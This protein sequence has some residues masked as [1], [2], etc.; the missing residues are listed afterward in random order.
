MQQTDDNE[1]ITTEE[2]LRALMGFP[3]ELVQRKAIT[4][5]DEACRDFIRQS[6]FALLSSSDASG[7]CDVSPRGDGPGFVHVVDEQHLVI[8][9]RPGNKRMD[10]LR[11]ILS[12]PQIGM[13]FLIP[14]L[15]ETLRVNGRAYLTK[16]RQLLSLMAVR[17]QVPLVGIVVQVDECFLH[18][19]KAFRRSRLWE[20]ES[21]L[22]PQE[23]PSAAQ[24]LSKHVKMDGMNAEQ[25]QAR[26]EDSY[27]NRLY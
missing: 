13:L 17:Q 27:R 9:E 10:T 3:S 6:P 7:Q 15:G 2:E 5:L 14:G 8:P 1:R 23:L 11:N 21:W 24:M 26:L 20:P 25:I 18:C 16:D 22:G 12:N 19:A 4:R